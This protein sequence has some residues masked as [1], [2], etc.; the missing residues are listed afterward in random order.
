MMGYV[1]NPDTTEEVCMYVCIIH[2]SKTDS[3]YKQGQEQEQGSQQEEY[4]TPMLCYADNQP[5]YPILY[6]M[7]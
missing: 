5:Y 3:F 7:P 2:L 6:F 4:K 1:Y